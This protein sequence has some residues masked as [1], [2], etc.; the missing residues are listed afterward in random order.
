MTVCED[1]MSFDCCH[2][3]RVQ[4]RTSTWCDTKL[5]STTA[6]RDDPFDTD[7]SMLVLPL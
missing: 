7:T 6:F 1:E 2:N 4:A 5:K 3:V